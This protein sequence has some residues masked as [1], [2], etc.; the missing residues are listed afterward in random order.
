MNKALATIILIYSYMVCG[1][2]STYYFQTKI[3]PIIF[4]IVGLLLIGLFAILGA[5]E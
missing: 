3:S 1:L 2:W 5:N 4:T